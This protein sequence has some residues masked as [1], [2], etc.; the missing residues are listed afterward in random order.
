MLGGQVETLKEPGRPRAVATA[1]E[2]G[3]IAGFVVRQ[4]SYL[5]S[6]YA[7]DSAFVQGDGAVR[8]TVHGDK[9]RDVLDALDIH[10]LQLPPGVDGKTATVRVNPAV[11]LRY[12]RG[13]A[14]LALAQSKSPEVELPAGIDLP[15]LGEIGLRIV[16]VAPPEAHRIAQTTDWHTTVLVPVPADA[17]SFQQVDVNGNHG[18]LIETSGRAAGKGE[19]R[20]GSVLLWSDGERVFA[21]TGRVNRVDLVQVASSVR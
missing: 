9:V 14:K 2:A 19:R 8:I 4:P 1:S 10:D 17:S 21:L 18:L 13:D 5:P 7:A 6:G 16:G 15:T 11:F 20:E 3:S 12:R